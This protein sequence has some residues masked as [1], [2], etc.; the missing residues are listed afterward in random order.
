MSGT[1]IQRL[2]L[3]LSGGNLRCSDGETA[4]DP[5]RP[6]TRCVFQVHGQDG[7]NDTF[8]LEYVLR[9]MRSWAHVPCD[10]YVRVQNTGVSVLFQ[11]FFFR[12]AASSLLPPPSPPAARAPACAR[13]G[14]ASPPRRRG[15]AERAASP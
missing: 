1:L 8:P 3:I 6:P 9:L 15:S 2:K 10:P 11:G 14:A 12:P 7:S 13:A 4:C 5:E